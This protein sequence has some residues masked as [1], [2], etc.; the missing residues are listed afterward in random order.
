MAD[1]NTACVRPVTSWDARHGRTLNG[2][3]RPVGWP[4]LPLTASTF[5]PAGPV[6]QFSIGLSARAHRRAARDPGC[7]LLRRATGRP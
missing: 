1:P 2:S 3:L 7:A 5:P 6:E 4:L